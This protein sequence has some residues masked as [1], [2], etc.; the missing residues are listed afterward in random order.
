M[1]A[2]CL[3]FVKSNSGIVV[4]IFYFVG[5]TSCT[6]LISDEFPEYDQEPVL[7]SIL[8]A[9]QQLEAH[10]SFAEEID[11][12]ILEGARNGTIYFSAGTTDMQVMSGTDSGLFFSNHLL[13]PGEIVELNAI[14]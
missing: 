7:N 6:T 10:L 14:N 9:G 2:S 4:I 5:I 12:T 11:S 8:I 13:V 3:P 1:M